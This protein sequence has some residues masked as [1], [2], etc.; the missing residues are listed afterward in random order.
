MKKENLKTINIQTKTKLVFIH[1]GS[2]P[3]PLL[4]KNL[5]MCVNNFETEIILIHSKNTTLKGIPK[6]VETY[7]YKGSQIF[8]ESSAKRKVDLEFR[9]GYWNFTLE[10]LFA[11]LDYQISQKESNLLHVE[12]DVLLLP[13]FPIERRLV[14]EKIMWC[15]SGDQ[16]DVAA[17]LYIPT[18][19]L[20]KYLLNT[21]QKELLAQPDLT[22]MQLLYKV[23]KKS[24]KIEL[25]SSRFTHCAGIDLPDAKEDYL[26]DL[27]DG[28]V[29][30]MWISGHDP[31]NHYGLYKLGDNSPFES[32]ATS[33]DPTTFTYSLNGEGGLVLTTLC[34]GKSAIL[35]NLHIHSKDKR[36]FVN[37]PNYRVGKNLELISKHGI[38]PQFSIMTLMSMA[39]HAFRN[40]E[41]IAFMANSP[42]AH[43]VKRLFVKLFK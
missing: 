25:F 32:G 23:R 35:H 12:S 41:L 2:L 11:L 27:F 39:H 21:F 15:E 13:S 37:D 26:C 34:C 16:H 29:F 33:I 42:I 14:S 30:G 28:A 8:L 38:V 19:E 9:R 10:R 6:E 40:M 18:V 31:R 4:I 22:D 43:W 1:L 3:N 7:I 17:L 36:F 5:K 24:N 20:A